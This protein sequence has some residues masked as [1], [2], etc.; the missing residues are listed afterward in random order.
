MS[1]T[2]ED[3]LQIRKVV[4]DVVHRELEPLTGKIEA[5]E[6]DIKEIYDMLKELQKQNSPV[7]S[8][9]KGSV[10]EKLLTLNADLLALAKQEGITLPR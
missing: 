7:P 6:N 10:E 4:E 2:Q 5:L 3:L 8:F 9:S 1:L